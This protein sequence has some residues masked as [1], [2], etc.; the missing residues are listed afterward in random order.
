MIKAEFSASLLQSSVSHDPTEI[1]LI[2]PAD[3]ETFLNII[4]VENSCVASLFFFF[5]FT[6]E[7]LFEIEIFCNIVTFD[8]L[9]VSMLNKSINS[10]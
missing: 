10:L 6:L 7:T 8:Q 9:N 4:N 5:F 1:I 2:R 3:Q